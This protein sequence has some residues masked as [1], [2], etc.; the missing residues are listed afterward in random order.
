[1]TLKRFGIFMVSA[2]ISTSG[3]YFWERNQNDIKA[4]DYVGLIDVST[5]HYFRELDDTS[6][7]NYFNQVTSNSILKADILKANI[8][9]C[10][11]LINPWLGSD[12]A[13][14]GKYKLD[15]IQSQEIIDGYDF[16]SITV[17]PEKVY[18]QS[19]RTNEYRY[20]YSD[21]YKYKTNGIPA[22]ANT[23]TLSTTKQ[24][25]F[26]FAKGVSSNNNPV[27]SMVFADQKYSATNTKNRVN[28]AIW[29][30]NG[31]Q[32]IGLTSWQKQYEIMNAPIRADQ[33]ASFGVMAGSSE[34]L[35]TTNN[36]AKI[37]FLVITNRVEVVTSPNGYA[38][39]NSIYAP[40]NDVQRYA[41]FDVGS[42]GCSAGSWPSHYA[43]I[44]IVGVVSYESKPSLLWSNKYA[45]NVGA[46]EEG[47][48]LFSVNVPLNSG[49][50]MTVQTIAG[51]YAPVSF[52][53]GI[54]TPIEDGSYNHTVNY[55]GL[56][57]GAYYNT[58]LFRFSLTGC[59]NNYDSVVVGIS[60][61]PSYQPIFGIV[62]PDGASTI[63]RPEIKVDVKLNFNKFWNIHSNEYRQIEIKDVSKTNLFW[64][65]NQIET[66]TASIHFLT[67]GAGYNVVSQNQYRV[68]YEG[69]STNVSGYKPSDDWCLDQM[70]T[71]ATNYTSLG[72]AGD[73]VLY[74]YSPA[75]RMYYS[76]YV[77][78]ENP[79]V[80]GELANASAWAT[81]K[82]N[83]K[84]I[85]LDWPSVYAITNG[86]IKRV[87]AYVIA[88]QII[89]GTINPLS[90]PTNATLSIGGNAP[91][92]S[93]ILFR[94]SNYDVNRCDY[95]IDDAI[96][97]NHY[98]VGNPV[99]S[100]IATLVYDS[101]NMT[102]SGTNKITF[103]L[104]KP[105]AIEMATPKGSF[106]NIVFNNANEIGKIA[107]VRDSVHQFTAQAK[108]R[109][110]CV[111]VDWNPIAW[112]QN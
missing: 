10:N 50:K 73:D 80:Y 103:K 22:L 92:N 49:A 6:I 17:A 24:G 85:T 21:Q 5:Q 45:V 54:N 16:A 11:N 105:H 102:G 65:K 12:G 60:T 107:E 66:N 95:P 94:L 108:I 96:S 76:R 36:P 63:Y 81:E 83:E 48:I 82:S 59:T 25:A 90:N 71:R 68:D 57:S 112:P 47:S 46:N 9:R 77:S 86:A 61:I 56:N 98:P 64:L 55:K 89:S 44:A 39:T 69:F 74:T 58:Q 35:S 52:T 87:R 53:A 29:E 18:A 15:A 28:G 26:P 67:L 72:V 32:K 84:W 100:S 4:K 109:K 43:S 78:N 75:H 20:I 51:D 70:F 1:M 111:V 93:D 23:W 34:N 40:S 106:Y 14:V 62:L 99:S 3:L 91:V 88:D 101:G 8:D 41:I 33:K 31:V 38:Y 79:T 7:T 2:I 110:L 19:G 27:L 13:S 104:N 30:T 97:F 42:A 37:T